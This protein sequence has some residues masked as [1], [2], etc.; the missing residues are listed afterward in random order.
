MS[1]DPDSAREVARTNFRA[2][3]IAALIGCVGVIVAAWVGAA[4][5]LSRGRHQAER[6]ATQQ[7]VEI[8][9]KDQQIARLQAEVEQ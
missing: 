9:Q 8:A 3:L 4:V 1:G 7:D 5:G 2:T 6:T